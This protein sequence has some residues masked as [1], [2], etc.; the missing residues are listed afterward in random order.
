MP[1]ILLFRA[2]DVRRVVDHMMAATAWKRGYGDKKRPRP[3]M[4]IVHDDGVYLMSN[5]DPADI[6]EGD[7]CFVAYAQGLDPKDGSHVWD[8]A[9]AVVG[10]DDFADYLD[11]TK[12]M[13]EA[14]R[15]PD[16]RGLRIDVTE[17]SMFIS[18]ESAAPPKRVMH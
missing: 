17:N 3:Q 4:I 6:I 18:I 2:E 16:F 5:G 14:I 11:L 13:I 1:G 8:A 9:R 10:G 15:S 7:R 12:E